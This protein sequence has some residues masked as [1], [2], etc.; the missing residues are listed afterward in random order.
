MWRKENLWS[1]FSFSSLSCCFFHSCLFFFLWTAA[2]N[3]RFACRRTPDL[4]ARFAGVDNKGKLWVLCCQSVRAVLFLSV[5]LSFPLVL[6]IT[7][8]GVTEAVLFEQP[9]GIELCQLLRKISPSLCVKFNSRAHPFTGFLP[10]TVLPSFPSP[11]YHP[12]CL[13]F[14]LSPEKMSLCSFR[15]VSKQVRLFPSIFPELFTG[16]PT[17][18]VFA[19]QVF[20]PMLSIS[21]IS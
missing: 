13:L 8:I 9:T 10:S 7:G 17:S 12:C 15:G 2:S 16:N 4:D 11:L 6:Q 1:W 5:S 3:H 20:L 18:L 14:Q 19:V 21:R